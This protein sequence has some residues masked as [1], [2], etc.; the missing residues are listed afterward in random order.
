MMKP[1]LD[2]KGQREEAAKLLDVDKPVD[3]YRNLQKG[4]W[5]VRQAGIVKY[6]TN[7]V[8]LRDVKFTVSQAG[9]NRVLREKRKNVHAFIRGTLAIPKTMPK[10]IDNQFTPVTY[11]PYKHHAF[12][13]TDTEYSVR[14]AE[15]VD[16]MIDDMIDEPVIAWGAK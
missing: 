14:T 6:H 15:W 1:F 3:V 16:M 11:N 12:I 8:F 13:R 9:R 10:E 2:S 4:C 7:Y 5:S